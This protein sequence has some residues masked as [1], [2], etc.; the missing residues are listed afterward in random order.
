MRILHV[1]SAEFFAGSVAYAVQLAEAHRAAGHA[2][3]LLSDA[4]APLPTGATQLHAPISD[5]RL[6]SR[7]RN[8]RRIRALVLELNIDVVHAHARAASWVAHAALRGL[9]VPLVSTVHGRQGL[10]RLRGL[11]VYGD[12]VLAICANLRTHLIEELGLEARKVALLPN[13]VA[14]GPVPAPPDAVAPDPAAPPRIALIGRFNGPKGERAAA[15]LQT[16]LP[17]LLAEFA[18]LRL[19]L[20]GGELTHLPA[21]GKA[22]LAA[23]QAEYGARIEVVGF[24]TDVPDWL[25]RSTVVVGAGRVAIEALGAGRAVLALGEALCAGLVTEASFAPA[26]ASN[27]GDIA[28]R[29]APPVPLDGPALTATLRAFLQNPAPVPAALVAQVRARYALP[30]VAAAVLETYQAARMARAVPGHLPVLMYHKVPDA[31]PASK[32]QTWVAKADF[33]RHLAFFRWR[34]LTP[35]TFADYLAFARAERPLADFPKRPVILTFDDGYADNYHNLLPLMQ[36][37]GYRGVL[38]L[39]G[40]FALDYNRWDHD[41]DPREPR[42]ALLTTAQKQAFVAAGWEI[43]AHTLTHP[44]LG[45]LP[46]PAAA[47][48]ISASKQALEAGLGIQIETF[49]YPYGDLSEDVKAAVRAAG[50]ALGIATDTGGLHLEDDRMQVFRV[51]MFPK[52]TWASLFKKTSGWYRAYYFRKRGR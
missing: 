7:W 1:L 50:F 6:G 49:A 24:T 37:Y 22:A 32:H 4:P 45:T 9:P 36:Q 30:A 3:W 26:A 11:D 16:V 48:E 23:L 13:G 18:T 46:L 8:L 19:A 15:L 27:F 5:R 31:A 20:V 14:F 33:A 52:E 43:G 21:A 35:L 10:H 38:F 25:A 34:G 51:N 39:L 42:A 28:A 2:V 44:R 17:P 47:H 29:Q 40:D 12:R 41:P